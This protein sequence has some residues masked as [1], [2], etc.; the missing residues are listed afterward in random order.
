VDRVTRYFPLAVGLLLGYLAVHPPAWLAALG[1]L[2]F[3][4]MAAVVL[5]LLVAFVVLVV[6]ANLPAEVQMRPA[7]DPCPPEL[8][9]LA[10]EYRALGFTPAGPLRE[11]GAAPPALVLAF[12]NEAR[13]T[14]GT[15]FRT[16]TV[17]SRVAFDFFS[18]LEGRE[19]GLSSCAA[20]GA[21]TLPAGPGAFSQILPGASVAVLFEAHRRAVEHLEGL[22]LR[23]RPVSAAT[24]DADFRA[25]LAQQRRAF[26]AAPLRNAAIAVWRSA[27]RTTPHLGAI[28][29]QR[30]AR[31]K[32]RALRSGLSA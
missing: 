31:R 11:V 23:F 7:A 10:R 12:T 26:L 25:G 28:E 27:T 24:F 5:L 32:I 8:E 21:G 13:R 2:R 30:A 18:F 14:Y 19:G 9:A 3:P 15:A 29:V 20:R 17:P 16:G 4:A 1:W 6:A 22:G